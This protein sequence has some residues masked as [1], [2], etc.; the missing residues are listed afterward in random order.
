MDE[1]V[2][3]GWTVTLPRRQGDRFIAHSAHGRAFFWKHREAV[4]SS[5]DLPRQGREGE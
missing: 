5:R 4:A 1:T 3:R 2:V